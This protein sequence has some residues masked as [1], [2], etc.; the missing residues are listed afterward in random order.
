MVTVGGM[1]LRRMLVITIRDSFLQSRSET[2]IKPLLIHNWGKRN[3]TETSRAWMVVSDV[4]A[5]NLEESLKDGAG[6]LHRQPAKE[7]IA[8]LPPER[9]NQQ[10]G[11]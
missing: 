10:L 11:R 8:G 5:N 7:K 4:C 1:S 6:S 2:E 9:A 3:V